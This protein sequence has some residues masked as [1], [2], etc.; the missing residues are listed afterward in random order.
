MPGVDCSRQDLGS[1]RETLIEVQLTLQNGRRNLKNLAMSTVCNAWHL[2]QGHTRGWA[3]CL[4]SQVA[5]F[6]TYLVL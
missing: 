5:P 6:S 3:A 1:R 2:N 4:A